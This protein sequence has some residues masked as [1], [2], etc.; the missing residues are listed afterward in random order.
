M[1]ND[2]SVRLNILTWVREH[3]GD[4]ALKGWTSQLQAHLLGRILGRKYDGDEDGNFSPEELQRVVFINDT[5]YQHQ[6]IQ[7]NYT[8]YDCRRAQETLSMVRDTEEA[9]PSSEKRPFILL[10]AHEPPPKPG[11]PDPHPYWYAEVVGIFHANV[12]YNDPDSFKTETQ[13]M[14][15]LWI[16][17]LG[18]R[19]NYPAGWTAKKLHRVAYVTPRESSPMFGFL[20][21]ANV[22][23]A[24]N[25]MPVDKYGRSSCR[26]PPSVGRPNSQDDLDW[27]YYDVGI[28]ADR[29][30][31]MRFRG[32]GVGH[33]STRE[34]TNKCL[35]DRDAT[36]LEFEL[37]VEEGD[38]VEVLERLLQNVANPE[39]MDEEELEDFLEDE[40]I[41]LRVLTGVEGD[42]SDEDEAW[43]VALH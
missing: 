3:S 18:P 36:D 43:P 31:F 7:I 38:D 25:L 37:D 27:N 10:Q 28:F 40:G 1:S 21:P 41:D 16:R 42:D 13:V 23:R 39:D 33:E 2:T 8:T 32:G 35:K 24:V 5:I 12:M 9:G 26:L 22:I 34:A 15:F 30:H 6:R 14:D 19:R 29:D 4:P 11:D 17:W 20:D